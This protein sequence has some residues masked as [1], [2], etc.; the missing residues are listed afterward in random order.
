MKI[1]A[2]YN[3]I[4]VAIT[5]FSICSSNSCLLYESYVAFAFFA[6]PNMQSFYKRFIRDYMRY[7][8][9]IQCAGAELVRAVREDALTLNPNGNGVYYALHVRRGDFQFKVIRIQ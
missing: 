4:M 6:D 7:K 3:I 5:S 1:T 8:D 9:N 2:S